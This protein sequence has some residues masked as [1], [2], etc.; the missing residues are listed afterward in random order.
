VTAMKRKTSCLPLSCISWNPSSVVVD[1]IVLFVF[2]RSADPGNSVILWVILA[3]H[4]HAGDSGSSAIGEL[5]AENRRERTR[6]G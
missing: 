3:R 1:A 6:V 2:Q 5:D 4:A